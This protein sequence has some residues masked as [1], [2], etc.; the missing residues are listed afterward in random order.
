MICFN[1]T[2]AFGLLLWIVNMFWGTATC[3]VVRDDVFCCHSVGYF[4][5]LEIW[6]CPRRVDLKTKHTINARLHIASATHLETL[7]LLE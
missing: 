2:V 1:K 3:F 7:T 6:M 4:L 5:E